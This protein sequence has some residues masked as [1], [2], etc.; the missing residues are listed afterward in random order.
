[1]VSSLA[2]E[3]VVNLATLVIDQAT[4]RSAFT[5]RTPPLSLGLMHQVHI[6]CFTLPPNFEPLVLLQPDVTLG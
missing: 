1:M 5:D 2:S 4:L 3:H 6:F